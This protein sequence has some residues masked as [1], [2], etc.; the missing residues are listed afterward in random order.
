MKELSRSAAPFSSALRPRLCCLALLVVAC[1]LLPVLTG[2]SG[3]TPPVGVT[4]KSKLKKKRKK[5]DNE[6]MLGPTGMTLGEAARRY[7]PS[8]RFNQGTPLTD[9]DYTNA[10]EQASH[11]RDDESAMTLA[12]E[13]IRLNPNNGEAYYVRG[14]AR[15]SG[16]AGND[17]APIDD[18]KKACKMGAGGASAWHYL[19]RAYDARKDFP[20]AIASI[21]EA[22]KM[23]PQDQ[24]SYK[25]RA[26]LYA[27]H[28]D[29]EKAIADYTEAIRV[30]A[31]DAEPY[32]LRAQIWETMK[33]DDE[34][35]KDYELAVSKGR[36]GH[37]V[38][39]KLM[40]YK[41]QAD[42]YLHR[43]EFAKSAQVLTKA[44]SMDK[45]DEELLRLRGEM[46]QKL[47]KHEQA[48]EDFSKAISLSPDFARRSYQ[49]RSLSYEKLG[50]NDLAAKDREEAK[51]LMDAPAEKPLYELNTSD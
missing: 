51:R 50:K 2:C 13:A 43:G 8:E 15:F 12:D 3:D 11:E 4:A 1:V 35:L 44:I 48:I 27:A 39:Y 40:S 26:T 22:I 23:R 7:V 38:P 6:D 31:Q 41:R 32:F 47:N 9:K 20:N 19:A 5:L 16:L 30:K 37:G 33:R 17:Q 18:L 49:S 14:K 45:T 10:A 36:E 29:K 42:I 25:T 34:A 28:G 46:Y 21:N 24:A